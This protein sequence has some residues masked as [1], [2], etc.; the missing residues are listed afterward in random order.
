[1]EISG[2]DT[3]ALGRL[4]PE[5]AVRGVLGTLNVKRDGTGGCI[6]CPSDSA[7]LHPSGLLPVAKISALERRDVPSRNWM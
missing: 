6:V 5:R 3:W 1:M 4:I 2:S 7:N